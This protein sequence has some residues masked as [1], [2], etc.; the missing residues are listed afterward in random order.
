[1]VYVSLLRGI[2]VGGN[3]KINMKLL[4]Q[5]FERLEMDSVVTYI[6]SGNIIFKSRNALSRTEIS[7]LVEE[8]ILVD[9]GL[10]IKVV[11]RSM[12]D[13]EKVMNLLPESWKND[14]E[15]K[16]DVM[17]LR[18]EMD[19]ESVLDHLVF[20]P[21]ID[22]VIYVEGAVLWSVDRKDETKSG[23]IKLVGSKVYKQMTIRNVNTTRKIYELMQAT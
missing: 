20:K 2:N 4:K 13:F 23:M 7:Q 6:N 18:D 15:M 21:E 16:S 19:D 8:A 17:F 1:M 14:Q 22:T 10:K 9:F 12:D 3:N 5:T 11:T